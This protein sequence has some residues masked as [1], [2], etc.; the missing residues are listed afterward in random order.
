MIHLVTVSGNS[1]RFTDKGYKHKALCDI[2]GHSVIETFINSFNDF[3]DYDT[4]FLC[5]DYDLENTE[6]RE[7]IQKYAPH[8]IIKGIDINISGPIYSITQIFDDLP[9]DESIVVSYID[10]L[11]KTTIK[12]LLDEFNGYDGGMTVHDFQ[13]PHWRV[14]PNYCLVEY[15]DDMFATN[16]I[17]KHKFTEDD[18]QNKYK[19][20]S[21][22]NYY[23][24]NIGIMKRYFR[25]LMDN[26]IRVNN[27]F[28]VTQA[29]EHMIKDGLNV[30]VHICPY[31]AL[32]V[33]ED[34]EDYSF[35]MRW[36]Q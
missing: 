24:K 12:T 21:S 26:N 25:Y 4:I 29:M 19:G 30:K 8:A 14:N 1:K 20:G 18:Y 35:W 28:Y 16:V 32:G 6:L 27:E 23:F 34:L 15:N 31:A 7:E 5:R 33:P 9:D 10:T 13:N 3:G 36:F 17:E 11:Q 22:G 2:N